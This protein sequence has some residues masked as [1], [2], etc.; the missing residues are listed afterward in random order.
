MGRHYDQVGPQPPRHQQ[1]LGSRIA[2]RDIH[3]VVVLRQ[4]SCDPERPKRVLLEVAGHHIRPRADTINTDRASSRKTQTEG[5]RPSGFINH[6]EQRPFAN[7]DDKRRVGERYERRRL[8]ILAFVR[9]TADLGRQALKVAAKEKHQT[10]TDYTLH[11]VVVAN[12]VECVEDDSVPTSKTT[13]GVSLSLAAP[14]S[15][16]RSEPFRLFFP[17]GV[18]FAWFGIG[19]WLLYTTGVIATYSCRFHGLVQMQAFM[20]AFAIG[21]LLTALPRRT[22]SPLVGRIELAAFAAAL[23]VTTAAATIDSW[24]LAEIAYAALLLLLIQFALRR[25]LTGEAGRRPPAAFVLLPIAALQGLAGAALIAAADANAVLPSTGYLGVLLVEQGVFLCLAIGMGSLVLPLMGGAPPPLD[26]GSAPRETWKAFAY[27]AA[28]IAIFASFLL[29]QL[30]YERGGPLLR[31]MVV[32][33]GLGFGGGALSL[34]RKPGVHRQLVW[35]AVWLMPVGLIASAIWPDYRVPALHILYIGGFSLLVFGVGSHVAMSHLDMEQ[36]ALG[37][38][39]AVVIL[40]AAFLISLGARLAADA[41][42]TYYVHLG[43][44]AG[45]WIAGSAVW[46]AFFGPKMLRSGGARPENSNEMKE[47]PSPDDRN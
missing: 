11:S 38:P 16:W 42:N 4:F 46:L 13:E 27:A 14:I 35:L 8:A 25:F 19:H 18:V 17:L 20:M 34:P 12:R 9:S 30:G 37:R 6:R 23:M 39:P 31:A 29:E 24:I 3:F 43:W 2:H 41:S 1:D 40:G 47:S 36:L 26:L 33:I 22:Q 7:A 45:A 28:G 5:N 15:C 21:F 10:E 44:A 32:A